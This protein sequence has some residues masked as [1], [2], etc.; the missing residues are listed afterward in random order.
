MKLRL[1]SLAVALSAATALSMDI[2]WNGGADTSWGTAANWEPP[3]VPGASDDV[4]ISKA[5]AKVYAPNGLSVNSLTLSG[6][7]VQLH[8]GD[9]ASRTSWSA[10]IAQDLTVTGSASLYA[11]AAA[12]NDVSV[13]TN[14]S[15]AIAAIYANATEVTVGGTFTVSDGG[16][17]YPSNDPCTATPVIFSA[18]DFNLAPD[19]SFNARKRGWRWV[20]SAA[21]G[22]TPAGATA[23]ARVSGGYTFAFGPGL[24][25]SIGG[26]YGG[27]GG[28][29]NGTRG[30]RYGTPFAP[31]LPGSPSGWEY[32]QNGSKII[33]P[34]SIVVF[35]SRTATLSG[36]MD[37]KGENCEYGGCS[38]GGIWVAAKTL[39][40]SSEAQLLAPAS[41]LVN[42]NYKGGGGGRIAL[43]DNVSRIEIDALAAAST[44]PPSFV[45]R[46]IVECVTDVS[47]AAMGEGD[48]LG[49]T[50]VFVTYCGTGLTLENRYAPSVAAEG[51]PFGVTRLGEG[52]A[53]AI[54]APAYGYDA[55]DPEFS[56]YAYAGYI[57]SNA[58]AQVAASQSTSLSFTP[59]AADGPYSVT[60]LWG[61]HEVRLSAEA[62]G[63]GVVSISGGAA[64]Q[65]FPEGTSVTLSARGSRERQFVC[66]LGDIPGGKSD[67]PEFTF[68]LCQG[69]RV[70]AVFSS[71]GTPSA[72]SWTGNAGTTCWDDSFNW[73]PVGVPTSGDDVTIAS[74]SV[75]APRGIV[76]SSLS[77][78][79]GAKLW[80][81][82]TGTSVT[83]APQDQAEHSRVRFLCVLNNLSNAGQLVLGGIGD[84]VTN[85]I[86]DVGCDMTLSGS[87]KTAVY[88][89]RGF[90]EVDTVARLFEKRTN[91][92]V[93][94]VLT[95]SE[96][97]TLYPVADPLTG[98][99]VMFT[100]YDIS[101]A[102]GATVNA[103][104][105]G[106]DG[107]PCRGGVPDARAVATFTMK[108]SG[109]GI[110]ELRET[111]A[112]GPGRDYTIAGGHGGRSVAASGVYGRSYGSP[113]A[114]LF[115]GA[116]SGHLASLNTY[117]AGGGVV[118]MRALN[119]FSADGTF[120]AEAQKAA[121]SAAAGGSIW[122]LAKTFDF[123]A[124]ARLLAPGGNGSYSP[125]GASGGGRI[126]LASGFTDAAVAEIA[127][128]DSLTE[129]YLESEI[130]ECE[131]NVSGGLGNNGASHGFDGTATRI[132]YIGNGTT[133]VY[134][135]NVPVEGNGLTMAPIVVADGDTIALEPPEYAY[136]VGSLENVRYSCVGLVVSNAVGEYMADNILPSS[137]YVDASQGPYTNVWLWGGREERFR[138]EVLGNGSV[139]VNGSSNLDIWHAAGTPLSLSAT[140]GEGSRFVCWLGDVPGGKCASSSLSFTP[141]VG[142][143]ATAVFA[144]TD[145]VATAKA[146][147]GG[148]GTSLWD[149]PD[150]WSPAG[151]PTADDDVAISSGIVYSPRRIVASS[152]VLGQNAS[153]TLASKSAS[154][155]AALTSAKQDAG[156][157]G[158]VRFLYVLGA[159]TNS[160]TL[161][162][163]GIG[164]AVSRFVFNVGG[165]LALIG[166]SKTAVYAART[167]GPVDAASLYA[168][169]TDFSIGGSLALADTAVL[170]PVCDPMTG[171]S[172]RFAAEKVSLA[173]GTQICADARG[174]YWC[175]CQN[176]TLAGKDPRAFCT[177]TAVN[178]D[179][180]LRE[181]FQ[182]LAPGTGEQY[183]QGAGHGGRGGYFTSRSATY[184]R[185]YDR[186]LAPV[187]P[188]SPNGIYNATLANSAQG[189]GVVWIDASGKAEIAGKISA[190]Q[191]KNV[192]FGGASG[193]SVWLTAGRFR[194][195][196]GARLQASGAPSGYRA[197]GGGGRICLTEGLSASQLASLGATGTTSLSPRKIFDETGF[198]ARFPDVTAHVAQGGDTRAEPGTFRFLD[199]V[200]TATTILL[201]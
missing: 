31:F 151:V 123:G 5:D 21:S 50:A 130:Q 129:D 199:G 144:R 190:S 137:L 102:S 29:Y 171:T 198:A 197:Q 179:N 86:F 101:V 114:P 132:A 147:T 10:S 17:V 30:G 74:G 23:S 34:G 142:A 159:V 48:P 100:A 25:Y 73:S 16:K 60:W 78:G 160:G 1:A 173:S 64:D 36:T 11:Y 44:L 191:S 76:V 69:G 184:G 200:P 177:A 148:A 145:G 186:E 59:S 192:S 22:G 201:R 104:G 169:R 193:G 122:L 77:L 156:E 43:V 149:D 117:S 111:F 51:L 138:A 133:L 118:W 195:T 87:S 189:G 110:N 79:A 124:N 56:R 24:S 2:L 97:A 165:D 65:W 84:A 33:A 83:A 42:A 163:G 140:A 134:D 3:L 49:G 183:W 125:G 6:N 38:G 131:Y 88:A 121:S 4:V 90:G 81:G 89:A 152:L 178:P 180:N 167:E 61:G 120:D 172:V 18:G 119:A 7:G 39:S 70:T 28:G 139:T 103:K 150:N 46:D 98:T 71:P 157:S 8:L 54:E 57:L 37:A 72:K 85:F 187:M 115:C 80:L 127:T 94:G 14:R 13:F 96:S 106:Y 107:L 15:Q 105:L 52:V 26:G 166:A 112:P 162:V 92:R 135:S 170:Y 175:R 153:L 155:S 40:V 128:L 188:G 113:Y 126:S 99:A 196:S 45:S 9:E 176:G 35:A 182:S 55:D 174:W 63:D 158:G 185:T 154:S 32:E 66:W 116:P 47:G 136:L 53:Y 62:A 146:W 27:S 168:A 12:L 141:V 143:K 20:K 19:G 58:T 108:N 161:I 82:S 93:G 181:P 194:F 91:F 75:Y 41:Y 68:T 95:L 109:T 67:N 164:D